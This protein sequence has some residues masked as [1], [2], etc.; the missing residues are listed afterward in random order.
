M[1]NI[2]TD[3]FF[4]SLCRESHGK[5]ASDLRRFIFCFSNFKYPLRKLVDME[6]GKL[7]TV[8][9]LCASIKPDL[10]LATLKYMKIIVAGII[11]LVGVLL[12]RNGGSI[13]LYLDQISKLVGTKVTEMKSLMTSSTLFSHFISKTPVTPST[14]PEIPVPEIPV[15][16]ISQQSIPI[17]DE[18]DFLDEPWIEKFQPKHLLSLIL[19]ACLSMFGVKAIQRKLSR[20]EIEEEYNWSKME[21]LIRSTSDSD[22]KKIY[23]IMIGYTLSSEE[24]KTVINLLKEYQEVDSEKKNTLKN[25]IVEYIRDRKIIPE[26]HKL[27]K[28]MSNSD[29]KQEIEQYVQRDIHDLERLDSLKQNIKYYN[30]SKRTSTTTYLGDPDIFEKRIRQ[31]I[32]PTHA[33]VGGMYMINNEWYRNIFQRIITTDGCLMVICMLLLLFLGKHT[34]IGSRVVEKSISKSVDN[35]MQKERI[36]R[37]FPSNDTI[38]E[39]T[40]LHTFIKKILTIDKHCNALV[41][42]SPDGKIR[43]FSNIRQSIVK[44]NFPFQLQLLQFIGKKLPT[45]TKTSSPRRRD[46]TQRSKKKKPRNE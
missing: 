43:D 27:L 40:A 20:N 45:N 41:I 42:F 46:K 12:Y 7:L 31:H 14:L 39:N 44:Y 24:M 37:I 28:E 25:N 17:S 11:L 13:D 21:E 23:I 22:L 8:S 16:E 5:D 26:I 38:E 36:D 30:D 2:N 34:M 29:L 33:L 32:H 9:Q 1:S 15:P 3:L 19:A 10:S 4:T 35:Q 6:T 18:S